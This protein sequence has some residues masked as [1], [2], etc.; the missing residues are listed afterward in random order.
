MIMNM[1]A[2]IFLSKEARELAEIA[3]EQNCQ[4]K[5]TQNSGGYCIHRIDNV[6]KKK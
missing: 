5:M 4:F 3:R 6:D 2:K 1:L